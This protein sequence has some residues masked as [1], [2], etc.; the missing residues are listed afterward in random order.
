MASRGNQWTLEGRELHLR[1]P[2]N[3][4]EIRRVCQQQ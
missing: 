2:A 3:A 1:L 4:N